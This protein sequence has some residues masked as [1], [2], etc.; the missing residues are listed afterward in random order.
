MAVGCGW[1]W[2]KGEGRQALMALRIPGDPESERGGKWVGT[3]SSDAVLDHLDH[4]VDFP[5]GHVLWRSSKFKIQ[6]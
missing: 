3:W 2:V 1:G 6:H 4:H 5:E